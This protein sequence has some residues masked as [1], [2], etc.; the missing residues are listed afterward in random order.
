MSAPPR[1]FPVETDNARPRNASKPALSPEDMVIF[2]V[3][4]REG[5]IRK[6]ALALRTPRSTVSRR[7]AELERALGGR[8]VSRSATRFSLTELG[9]ALLGKCTELEE[10]LRA[11]QA[12]TERTAAEP[13][14]TLTVAASPAVGEDLLPEVIA[15]FRKRF[16]LVKLVVDLSSEFVDLSGG[17]CDVAI[18]TGPLAEKN[19]LYAVRVSTTFRG[20]YASAKYLAAHGTPSSPSDLSAHEC[21]VSAGSKGPQVWSFRVQ[22]SELHVPVNGQL[23]VNSLRLARSAAALGAG[24]ARL[25]GVFAQPLVDEKELIPVLEKFW[26][27]TELFAVHA[28]GRPAPPKIR[29]FIELL[30]EKLPRPGG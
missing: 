30:K 17:A 23:R 13:A 29:A 14:G 24:I 21:I 2:S 28:A 20:C 6:G 1:P 15:A 4:A 10:L 7:L 11:T 9:A 27:R 26:Q 12:V 25:P 8:L 16:P 19:E 3:V 5:G 18:R 22:G